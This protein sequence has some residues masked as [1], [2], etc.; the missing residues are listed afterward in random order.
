MAS[1]LVGGDTNGLQ[2][3]F[4]RDRQTATTSRVS[5]TDG[6]LEALGASEAPTISD[7]GNLV[8]FASDAALVAGDSNSVRD[9][10]VRDRTAGTTTRAS[11]S[12][13]GG[14]GG[15]GHSTI[16]TISDDGGVVAFISAK[17]NL[18]ADDTNAATDAFAHVRAA[19]HT[20]RVSVAGNAANWASANPAVSND[21]R[22]VAFESLATNLVPRDT[23]GDSDVFVRDHLTGTVE[24]VSVSSGGVQANAESFHPAISGDGRY[25]VFESIATNLAPDTNG[26]V[27]DI[28][29]HDRVTDLT[30][31]V[32][33]GEG[34][35]QGSTHHQNPDVS[36]DGRYIVFDTLSA[37]NAGDSNL[38]KDVYKRD[39]VAGS[40]LLVSRDTAN[41]PANA[42]SSTPSM[43]ADGR[44]V[45]FASQA[46]DL[47][48]ND[49]NALADVF[50]RD[51]LFAGSTDQAQRRH[52]PR[53]GQQRE[54]E[55]VDQRGRDQDRL[56]VAG[57]QPRHRRHQRTRRH[58]R[59]QHRR[60]L[61]DL[62]L[63]DDTRERRHRRRTG[64]QCQRGPEHE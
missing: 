12:T 26:A 42:N 25:V 23:N 3:I 40:T 15:G 9:I 6:E 54:L 17:T 41:G 27:R 28:F 20:E 58:L 7:S 62:H 18:V 48:A 52:L 1:N 53:A 35:N 33:V 4:V 2:D 57:H 11:V 39:R 60:Q 30:Q 49:T 29:W 61:P 36:D 51:T 45:A 34:E 46:S 55:P 47:V 37:L 32:S 50:R 59:P 21:G 31:L 56:P 14:Q 44:Y 5:L 24:R 10:Y 64:Q 43:T 38:A 8:A 13:G 63:H 16:A 22:Y 19:T